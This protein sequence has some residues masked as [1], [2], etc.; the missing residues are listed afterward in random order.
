MS[1][2]FPTQPLSG[3]GPW[4]LVQVAD[5]LGMSYDTVCRDVRR[6]L[7]PARPASRRGVGRY[8]VLA[9]DLR[10]SP[11]ARYR[12]LVPPGLGPATTSRS[13]L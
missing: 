2:R 13:A 8:E 5:A 1:G 9:E 7:L 10:R 3:Q 12:Q 11:L 6:G 4:T